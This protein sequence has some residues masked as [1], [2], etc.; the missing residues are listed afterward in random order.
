M[1]SPFRSLAIISV[2]LI[3][4]A[5]AQIQYD[6]NYDD[7]THIKGTYQ[8][9]PKML[10]KHM[11]FISPFNAMT[12]GAGGFLG[13]NLQ[14]T[15]RNNKSFY[16]VLRGRGGYF[17][18]ARSYDKA[19]SFDWLTTLNLILFKKEKEKAKDV[20]LHWV[21]TGSE[22]AIVYPAQNFPKSKRRTLSVSGGVNIFKY[23]SEVEVYELHDY[24]AYKAPLLKYVGGDMTT[25]ASSVG[26][27]Y[28]TT[29]SYLVL[30]NLR[31]YYR[32]SSLRWYAHVIYGY[33]NDYKLYQVSDKGFV[34]GEYVGLVYEDKTEELN[35]SLNVTVN[36]IGMRT[37]FERFQNLKGNLGL[38]YGFDLLFIP[39][40]VFKYV[41]DNASIETR[42]EIGGFTVHVGLTFGSSPWKK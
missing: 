12:T 40:Y 14:Y 15:Y 8:N 21:K 6:I 5:N 41:Y 10:P 16:W 26:L 42:S 18:S 1:K 25:A 11:G 22:T 20:N 39:Q 4:C 33:Y 24:I 3:N 31:E 17:R 37:G 23:N 32:Y 9:D 34:G 30:N 38:V 29:K 2:V 35:E 36:K 19:P 7:G 13:Y 27:E 28:E